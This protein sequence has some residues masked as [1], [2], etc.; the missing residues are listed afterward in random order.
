MAARQ[1]RAPPLDKKALSE[2]KKN[3]ALSSNA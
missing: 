2:N 3:C 1:R